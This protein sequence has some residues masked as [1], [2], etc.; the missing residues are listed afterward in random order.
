MITVNTTDKIAF[1]KTLKTI[2]TRVRSCSKSISPEQMFELMDALHNVP[3]VFCDNKWI[4]TEKF[5]S[6]YFDAY[7]KKWVGNRNDGLRL[8]LRRT[9]EEHKTSVA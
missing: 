1:A 5:I 8:S 4:V 6:M 9:F 3:D 2:M 7:D